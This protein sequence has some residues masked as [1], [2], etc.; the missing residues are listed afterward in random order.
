MSRI[1]GD[2]EFLG[3]S[4]GGSE[5]SYV[6]S[7]GRISGKLLSA[8]L[9]RNGSDLT[10]RNGDTDPDLLYLDVNNMRI[11]V[12]TDG[13]LNDFEINGNSRVNNN[14]YVTDT[15]ATVSNLI[16]GTNGTFST[17]VGPINIEPNGVDAFV[18]Y[19]RLTTPSFEIHNNFIINNVEDQDVVLTANGSGIV[20]IQ[21][22]TDITGDLDVIGNIQA[23]GNIQLNGTFYI[24]DSPL[25]TVSIN[26]DLTQSIIPG[27]D[28]TYSLGTALK[29]WD[30]IN[31]YNISGVNS[32]LVD[33]IVVG[34]QL[35]LSG[36]SITT[37]NSNDP[38]IITSDSGNIKLEDININSNTI[39]NLLDTPLVLRSTGNGYYLFPD[40]HALRVPFGNTA[41]RRSTPEVGETRWNTDSQFLECFDGTVWQVST[42]GGLVVTAPYME[43]LSFTWTLILG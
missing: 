32:V 28:N 24:G 43:E 20:D 34:N 3:S 15:S 16:I 18:Q 23:D 13:P 4:T 39:T 8:N 14:L 41:E 17:I 10:F 19:D 9:L 21:N 6:A 2:D 7:L 30:N 12:N 33:N 25:D 5:S 36:N 26:P 31:L 40:T 29:K 1:L 42:G 35:R 38:I 27:V 37:D 11:G 22:S